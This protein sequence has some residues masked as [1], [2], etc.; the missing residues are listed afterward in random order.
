MSDRV[1]ALKHELREAR[2]WMTD[3]QLAEVVT[4]C[5]S[6][7]EIHPFDLHAVLQEYR[8]EVQAWKLNEPRQLL[9][10]SDAHEREQRAE[11]IVEL[12]AQGLTLDALAP[13]V[14]M[15]RSGL[16]SEIRRLRVKGYV[17]ATRPHAARFRPPRKVA[18]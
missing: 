15:S 14:G 5:A 16:V 1:I 13:L 2:A 12:W 11:R 3:P 18:A 4:R 17:L 6:Y 8:P 7:G 9:S 10:L